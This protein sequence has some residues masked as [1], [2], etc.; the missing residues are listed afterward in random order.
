[1]LALIFENE[2]IID[3]EFDDPIENND[4]VGFGSNI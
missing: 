3:V 2:F 4:I 1:M